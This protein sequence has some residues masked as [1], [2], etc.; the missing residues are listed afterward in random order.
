MLGKQRIMQTKV[1]YDFN[2]DCQGE[3]HILIEMGGCVLI[4]TG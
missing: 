2:H 4:N 3:M 1:Q